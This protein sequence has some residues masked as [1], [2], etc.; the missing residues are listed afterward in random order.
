[1]DVIVTHEFADLDALAS[2]IAASLLYE[3]AVCLRN[4]QVSTLTR[5]Y[6]A[7]HKD[8]LPL[9]TVDDVDPREVDRFIA[10][11]TRKAS[12]L[13]E[14]SDFLEAADEVCVW[15]HHPASGDD[16]P[17]DELHIEPVGACVTLLTEALRQE[18]T[19]PT[20]EQA[21]LMLLG[22][23]ADTGSLT[24]DHTT[25]RDVEAGAFMLRAGAQLPV[26]NRYLRDQFSRDQRRLLADLMSDDEELDLG[27]AR[28]VVATAEAEG[29]VDGAANVV[30]HMM[31][32][33]GH[34]AMFAIIAF[35]G[36]S[37]IQI[38]ARSRVPYVHVGEI[39]EAFGGGGAPGGGR[40][41]SEGEFDRGGQGRAA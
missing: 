41:E 13:R 27:T 38:V 39:C 2:L 30:E 7:L 40:G 3:D 26:V 36:V 10:V 16:I 6:L 9:K 17:A 24:F 37:R 5:R 23:Y 4:G 21:T 20:E 8:A 29:Y 35:N 28:I 25:A 18:G 22:L 15:D 11:D 14:F 1:M 19:S 34:E 12:R 32:M 31:E 33:L